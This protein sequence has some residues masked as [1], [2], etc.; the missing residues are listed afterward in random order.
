MQ[1]RKPDPSDP[2]TALRRTRCAGFGLLEAIV[3]LVL[4][5]ISVMAVYNWI[6][7]NLITISRLQAHAQQS[8]A[9]NN[10]LAYLDNLNPMRK[11]NGTQKFQGYKISWHSV[12]IEP[13]RNQVASLSGTGL[14]KVGLYQVTVRVIKNPGNT[15][16]R[17]SFKQAGY[18]QVRH[19]FNF[20]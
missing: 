1:H 14:Y 4:I 19:A 15:W 16:F 11:P 18:L 8:A 10:V 20:L 7:A 6:S 12:P 3:A 9:Q 13:A 5:S 2:S 17:F